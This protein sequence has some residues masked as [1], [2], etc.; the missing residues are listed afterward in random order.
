M[1]SKLPEQLQMVWP[2]RLF[3]S[4]PRSQLSSGYALRTFR[5]GDEPRFFQIMELS[6]WPGWNAQKLRPWIPRILPES[7]F[8]AIHQESDLIVATAMGVHDPT[9][10]HP[11]GGE[12]GWVASDPAH[13][14]RGLGQA[15]SAA[16]TARLIEAGYREIHLYT[17]D[18]RLPALKTYLKL[19]YVPFLFKPE[20]AERWRQ[21]CA[22]LPWPFTPETWDAGGPLPRP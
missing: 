11:F 13:R 16:V 10:R 8:L 18:F 19:G 7:W 12:L 21:I 1:D 20:M 22:R 3:Q 9:D 6:G 15:V 4:P 14:G 17:D 2:R 5:P